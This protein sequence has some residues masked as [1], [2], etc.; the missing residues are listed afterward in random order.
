MASQVLN[1]VKFRK[2]NPSEFEGVIVS[3]PAQPYDSYI[4]PEGSKSSNNQK[5]I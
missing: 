3:Q 5:M 1:E 2:E 4:P